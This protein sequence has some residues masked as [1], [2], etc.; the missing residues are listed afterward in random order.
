[1]RPVG[2]APDRT[3]PETLRRISIQF[4]E[5]PRIYGAGSC[6]PTRLRASGRPDLEIVD[7]A[8]GFNGRDQPSRLFSS[9]G[10]RLGR[11]RRIAILWQNTRI[12]T[13]GF[14]LDAA[15]SCQ[16]SFSCNRGRPAIEKGQTLFKLPLFRCY[17]YRQNL[18]DFF[19]ERPEV[20]HRHCFQI[21]L[22]HHGAAPYY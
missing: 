13:P 14:T 20:V 16:L 21:G 1:M 9:S 22:L 11:T 18:A 4:I 15:M 17:S 10:P 5:M 6:P 12:F 3:T 7:L 8:T 19:M 2:S